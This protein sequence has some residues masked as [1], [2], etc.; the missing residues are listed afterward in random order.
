MLFTIKEHKILTDSQAR[1][2]YAL[3]FMIPSYCALAFIW[4][5]G[6]HHA[7]MSNLIAGPLIFFVAILLGGI[8][9]Y[10]KFLLEELSAQGLR[11]LY[12]CLRLL[13]DVAPQFSEAISQGLKLRQ[14]D[15]L[16]VAALHQIALTKQTKFKAA[17]DIFR[18]G[19]SKE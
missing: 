5:M 18:L 14:R 6:S 2:R 11:K 15:L 7:D 8:F 19:E 1:L 9:M 10:N 3:S 12:E 13:P 4:L 17:S 16:H